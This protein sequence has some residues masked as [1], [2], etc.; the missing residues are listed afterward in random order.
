MQMR[1]LGRSGPMVS[2]LGLG[3]VKLGRNTGVKYPGAFE[4]PSDEAVLELLRTALDLGVNLLDTAPAYG[5]AEERLGALLPR[6]GGRER[7]I[8]VTKAGEEFDG[9]TGLSRFDFSPGAVRASVERSLVRLRTDRLD[10]VL[11]HSDGRDEAIIAGGGALEE[12]AR[13]RDEGKVG[14]IG[15][16]TKTAAGGLLAVRRGDFAMLTLNGEQRDDLPAIG[17][18]ERLGVGVLIKK[19]LASGH[20]SDPG[21][22]VRAAVG[23][24][25]VT[26][27]I[28]GTT[29]PAHLRS[30]A[31]AAAAG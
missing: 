22:A 26:S 2:V 8:I 16:S 6:V 1:R 7:W 10:G 15:A 11:L 3:T 17:E 9:A 30:N 13:L 24:A 21:S 29:S 18:A 20:A 25:G 27:V 14:L 19:A 31:C 28:V 5:L 12:L 4:L 23:V